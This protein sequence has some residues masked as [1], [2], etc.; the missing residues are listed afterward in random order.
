MAPLSEATWKKTVGSPPELHD[1]VAKIIQTECGNN[2]RARGVAVAEKRSR[3]VRLFLFNFRTGLASSEITFAHRE[4]QG[5][6]GSIT[7]C[8]LGRRLRR[9]E[10]QLKR[11]IQISM[12]SCEDDTLQHSEPRTQMG[13]ST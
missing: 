3:I 2:L 10:C 5:T 13:P 11:W 12:I 7:R 8:R 1:K 6:S 9:A 4:I